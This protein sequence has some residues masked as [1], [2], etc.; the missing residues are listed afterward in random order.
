MIDQNVVNFLSAKLQEILFFNL[1][2]FECDCYFFCT[3]NHK[4]NNKH[5]QSIIL[6]LEICDLEY[7][8]NSELNT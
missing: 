4:L 8:Y 5:P 3:N 6:Y 7:F 1:M 2:V